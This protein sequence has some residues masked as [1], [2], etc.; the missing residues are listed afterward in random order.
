M[1]VVNS[2]PG[3]AADAGLGEGEPVA[4]HDLADAFQGGKGGVTL[5]QVRHL[6]LVAESG[7]R[8]DAAD[9]EHELLL[10]AG[11]LVATVEP[12]RDA[13]DQLVDSA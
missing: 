6:G 3:A 12:C 10:D 4:G 7:E 9:T 1:W 2:I 13:G 5:I 8:T 11:L